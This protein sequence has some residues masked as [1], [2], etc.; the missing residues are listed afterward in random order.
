MLTLEL[1]L[2]KCVATPCIKSRTFL[3][4][5]PSSFYISCFASES[6][7]FGVKRDP[8]RLVFPLSTAQRIRL[9][10][11]PAI[12]RSVTRSSDLVYFFHPYRTHKRGSLDLALH[13]LN[14]DHILM[15][16]DGRCIECPHVAS[17]AGLLRLKARNISAI[18]EVLSIKH[19][20]RRVKSSR[21]YPTAQC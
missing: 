9:V 14:S 20:E 3:P 17:L 19:R 4:S 8:I 21:I 10:P 16:N 13:Y 7:Q 18:H 2:A 12:S 15:W 5:S 6:E 1:E 11:E